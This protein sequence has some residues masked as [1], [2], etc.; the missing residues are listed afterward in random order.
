MNRNADMPGDTNRRTGAESGFSSAN[1]LPSLLRKAS[2][3]EVCEM[4]Q[5]ML[6]GYSACSIAAGIFATDISERAT[7]LSNWSAFSS[8]ASDFDSKATIALFRSC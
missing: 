1:V 4:R 2:L 8:S 6:T 7:W 3:T 5:F